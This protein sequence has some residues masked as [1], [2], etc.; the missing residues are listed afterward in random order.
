M[1]KSVAVLVTTIVATTTLGACGGGDDPYCDA[2]QKNKSSLDS[3]GQKRTNAAYTRY[4]KVLADVAK[5]APTKVKKDWTAL[6]KATTDIVAAQE[7][8]GIA[9]EKMTDEKA[10]AAVSA[11]KREQLN[12]AYKAFNAT[13]TQRDA[14]VKNVLQECDIKLK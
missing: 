7:T 13:T 12:K 3:F 10:L 6:S 5:T 4:A 2:V 9:L 14:V 11:D 1:K 8:A